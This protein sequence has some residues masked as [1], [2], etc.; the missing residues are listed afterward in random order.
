VT[1]PALS[2]ALTK[3]IPGARYEEIARA[4]H[5]SNLERPDEFNLLVGAFVREVD[6]QAP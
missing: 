5:L 3:L 6:L 2:E 1:S 4:G